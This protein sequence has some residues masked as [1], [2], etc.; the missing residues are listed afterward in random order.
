MELIQYKINTEL[1]VFNIYNLLLLLCFVKLFNYD[2][3]YYGN[4]KKNTI[5]ILS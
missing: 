2:V 1:I 3:L 5:Y 4:E